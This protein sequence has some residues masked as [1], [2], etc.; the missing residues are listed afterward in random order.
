MEASSAANPKRFIGADELQRLSERLAKQIAASNFKPTFLIVL[1]R[2]GSAIGMVVQEFLEYYHKIDID[3]VPVRTISRDPV[4]GK[5]LPKIVVHAMGHA[6][7]TLQR[8]DRLLIMDDVS[9]SG[10]SAQAVEMELREK[11]GDRMPRDTRLAVVFYKPKKNKSGKVPDFFVEDS[12]A[13]LV[14]PHELVGLSDDE[15]LDY[16]P[17][18]YRMMEE[19]DQ[20]K[21]EQ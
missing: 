7:S 8:H 10:L 3:H 11:L 20:E 19:L 13:W 14:F 16:R 12:D 21:E 18:A 4:T 1:W 9:D 5:P 6:V 15:V 17:H 2:G